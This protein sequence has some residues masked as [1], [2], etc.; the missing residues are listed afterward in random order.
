MRSLLLLTLLVCMH[1][2]QGKTT[3]TNT[4]S[5]DSLNNIIDEL[6]TKTTIDDSETADLSNQI[7]HLSMDKRCSCLA[8]ALNLQGFQY[9]GKND[10][11]KAKELFFQ[12]EHILKK[13]NLQRD[14][15]ARNQLFLG[16]IYVLE[17]NFESAI[18]YFGNS[19]NIYEQISD[20]IGIADASLN[21]GLAYREYGDLGSAK[22]Q[23]EMAYRE[24]TATQKLDL[25]GYS[26]QN[27]TQLYIKMGEFDKAIYYADLTEKTWEE[28][29]YPKGLYYVNIIYSDIYESTG[30]TKAQIEHLQK[31]LKYAEKLDIYINKHMAY[32]SLGKV[33]KKINEIE[34]AQINFEKALSISQY[35]EKEE[36][37]VLV[38]NLSNIYEKKKDFSKMKLLMSKMIDFNAALIEDRVIESNKWVN[39]QNSLEVV[40]TENKELSASKEKSEALVKNQKI[41]I[42]LFLSLF[43]IIG[44]IAYYLYKQSKLRSQL[45]EK[46]RNQNT[47]L[48][49]V[50]L[51]LEKSTETIKNQNSKLE[52]KN[53]ELKNFAAIASH[54]L[55]SPARTIINFTGL[56]KRKLKRDTEPEEILSLV[57]SIE[58]SS[59]NMYALIVDL[60]EF[61]K[62]EKAPLNL[63]MFDANDLIQDLLLDMQ[64]AIDEKNVKIEIENF[65]L[66]MVG[67]PIKLKQV[68][69]NLINNG[70]K[71][72][73][74]D[75]SPSLVL[76]AVEKEAEYV[77]HVKDNGIGI[78]AEYKEKIFSMFQR[79]NTAEKYEGTGIGLAIC[80]KVIALHKGEI[81][82]D[83]VL[84]VGSTFSF[85]ISKSLK[86]ESAPV[87]KAFANT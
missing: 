3:L 74:E 12:A 24:S 76:S 46:I 41:F 57:E 30:D 71:F 75:V 45:I 78:E 44:S 82:V 32:L 26:L 9:Y 39:S 66:Q 48:F 85:T 21:L 55:K 64:S 38:F 15:L 35:F 54:D 68:F 14:V 20:R 19:K 4:I 49:D 73:K 83:S 62:L 65:P 70:L 18:K 5:C 11:T 84:Q 8:K 50:N 36:F 40:K 10:L 51:K 37:D 87:A 80:Q 7:Y 2:L 58:K 13:S 53:E 81:W 16:L 33:Y 60:L 52:G 59:R 23:L 69:L 25:R 86:A 22:L 72:T 28:F 29:N 1:S 34:K 67:D 43:I 42:A 47:A 77:F 17:R 56:L 27:L 61:A 63:R 31:S 6:F 79:L